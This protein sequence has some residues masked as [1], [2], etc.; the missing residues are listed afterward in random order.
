[1]SEETKEPEGTIACQAVRRGRAWTVH[2]PEHGVYA[3]GRTLRAAQASTAA[4]LALVG[5]TAPVSL[6][7]VSPELAALRDA[8]AAREGALRDA[9]AALALRRAT[10]RDI[11]QATGT[12][13]RRVRTI[14]AALT[15]PAESGT[16]EAGETHA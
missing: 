13:T 15:A 9:V 14:L 7:A 4:G 5:V 2:V 16:A 6:A 12:T 8:D 10:L 11:A 1:M 3:H